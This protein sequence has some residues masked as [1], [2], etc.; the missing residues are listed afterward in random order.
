MMILTKEEEKQLNELAEIKKKSIWT[1]EEE[2]KLRLIKE[3]Y[4][5]VGPR[6]LNELKMFPNKEFKQIKDKYY[7]I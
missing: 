4:P 7:K 1:E 2:E 6:E 5:E 3:K